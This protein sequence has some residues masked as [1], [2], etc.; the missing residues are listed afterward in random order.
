MNVKQIQTGTQDFRKFKQYFRNHLRNEY[1]NNDRE[2]KKTLLFGRYDSN[3]LTAVAIFQP[4][5]EPTLHMG[6]M[7][8]ANAYRDIHKFEDVAIYVI[9]L[10][11]AFKNKNRLAESAAAL[12]RA[13]EDYL[14]ERFGACCLMIS[15][16]QTANK[17]AFPHYSNLGFVKKDN[18]DSYHMS[19]DLTDLIRRYP[20]TQRLQSPVVL[21]S[22]QT[23]TM[24][25]FARL[26]ECY[27]NVF[28]PDIPL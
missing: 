11:Y 20:K 15:L 25:D 9:R 3:E 27:K 23:M 17:K 21:K 7:I 8:S 26:V 1:Y 6:S 14:L 22:I 13:C 19:I 16:F 2:T 4:Y 5:T 24:D 18:S 28:A 10:I 12:I